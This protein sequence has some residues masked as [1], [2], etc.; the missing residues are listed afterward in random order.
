MI[1]ILSIKIL[2]NT[3][4]QHVQCRL[5][6]MVNKC[7]VKVSTMNSNNLSKSYASL[8]QS[9]ILTEKSLY[10]EICLDQFAYRHGFLGGGLFDYY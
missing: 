6:L 1:D 3:H 7:P 2:Y 8:T 10:C 9:R 5:I 4:I